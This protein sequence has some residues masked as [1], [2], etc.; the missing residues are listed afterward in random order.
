G[1]KVAPRPP[2][3][4]AW[5]PARLLTNTLRTKVAAE[6]NLSTTGGCMVVPGG[7]H[8]GWCRRGCALTPSP[9]DTRSAG[10]RPGLGTIRG[11]PPPVIKG[12]LGEQANPMRRDEPKK[13]SRPTVLRRGRWPTRLTGR[14]QGLQADSAGL[15]VPPQLPG[16]VQEAFA[17]ALA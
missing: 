2:A 13:R 3:D 1:P 10:L 11:R 12:G 15:Q 16:Q 14:R 9:P 6:G 4:G 5:V 7:T 8:R 17:P